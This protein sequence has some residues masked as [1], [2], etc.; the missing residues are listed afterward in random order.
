MFTNTSCLN[1]N[2]LKS[3]FAHKCSYVRP[4]NDIVDYV[5][6]IDCFS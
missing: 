3:S 4:I 2:V 5:K 1:K 6:N